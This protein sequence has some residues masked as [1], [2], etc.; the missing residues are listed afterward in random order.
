MGSV[1]GSEGARLVKHGKAL[2]GVRGEQ[3]AQVGRQRG[4]VAGDVHDA[5]KLGQQRLRR[6]IQ[7]RTR[8]VHLPRAQVC[9]FR[10]W[11]GNP[12]NPTCQQM[13]SVEIWQI[14]NKWTVL[15]T[16]RMQTTKG[17]SAHPCSC[18]RQ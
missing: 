3:R 7:A 16:G 12:N 1:W 10:D 15:N 8:R 14:V 5:L 18:L 2:H 9:C 13:G 4:R 11:A 17:S 6:G